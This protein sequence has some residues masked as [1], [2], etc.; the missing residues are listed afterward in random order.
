MEEN[1]EP[2]GSTT[3]MIKSFVIFLLK[4]VVTALIANTIHMLF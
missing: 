4:A 1:K 3:D 2:K